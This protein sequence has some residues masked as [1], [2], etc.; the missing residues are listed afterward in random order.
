MLELQQRCISPEPSKRPAA[1]EIIEAILSLPKTSS[2]EV[3]RTVSSG[4]VPA[5]QG[6]A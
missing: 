1:T 3:C 4:R 6:P 2:G 5:A